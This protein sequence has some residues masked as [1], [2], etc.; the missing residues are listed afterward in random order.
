I[1]KDQWEKHEEVVVS[2]ADFTTSIKGY[3]EENVDHGDQTNKLVQATMN[4][5]DKNN[6]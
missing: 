4:S 1:A 5:L 2:Y 3:Y 6:T